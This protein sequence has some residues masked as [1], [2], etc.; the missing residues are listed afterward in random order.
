MYT[1][2]CQFSKIYKIL[3]FFI[4]TFLI[5]KYAINLGTT[6]TSMIITVIYLIFDMYFPTVRCYVSDKN[7][8]NE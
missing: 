4:L 8:I 3:M 1:D 2:F 5:L 6:Y 7:H